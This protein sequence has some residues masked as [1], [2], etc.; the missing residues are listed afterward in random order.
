MDFMR[1]SPV[2]LYHQLKQIFLEKIA[3]GEWKPGDQ[4][5]TEQEFSRQYGVSRTTVRQ[6]L[7]ELENERQ[8]YRRAGRGTFITD[9]KYLEGPNPYDLE[10]ANLMAQGHQAGWKLLK[11]GIIP[12]PYMA[13][14]HLNIAEGQPVFHILRLRLV[15]DKI[16]GHI[17]SFLLPD[18]AQLADQTLLLSGGSMYYLSNLDMSGCTTEHFL[19]VKIASRQDARLLEVETGSPIVES[20]RILRDKNFKPFEFFIGT[21]RGDKF[22]YHIHPK[23]VQI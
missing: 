6:A 7:Q 3:K 21:Y 8:I 4:I 17:S 18:I 22:R 19:E 15:D 23:A 16:I 14:T 13:A 11:K 9:V 1:N 10:N 2:P 12:A 5:P 20:I